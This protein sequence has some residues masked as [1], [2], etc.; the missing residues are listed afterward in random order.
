VTSEPSFWRRCSSCKTEIGFEQ[1]HWVCSVSTCNRKRTGLIFCSVRCWDTHLPTARHRDAWAVEERSPS[2]AQ[3]Q[4]AA[5]GGD[6]RGRASKTAA[7]GSARKSDPATEILV[8]VSRLKNFVKES[9][10]MST[11]DGVMPI[12]SD[13]LRYLADQA[14]QRAERHGR[15]TIL[16]RDMKDALKGDWGEW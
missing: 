4:R 14:A 11:S 2:L 15:R 5:A 8:V 7:G 9:R 16:E 13:H 1:R 10:G 3:V 6:R 12:L